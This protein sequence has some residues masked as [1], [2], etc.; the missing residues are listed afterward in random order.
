MDKPLDAPSINGFDEEVKHFVGLHSGWRAP[1][2]FSGTRYHADADARRHLQ[3]LRE[4]AI[5]V[6]R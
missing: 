4:G 5:S 6:Y 1:D 2:L 3:I